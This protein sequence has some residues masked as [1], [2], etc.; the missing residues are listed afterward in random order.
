M[1]NKAH[2]G[3][4][5]NMEQNKFESHTKL[6]NEFLYVLENVKDKNFF[7]VLLQ[8]GIMSFRR[9]SIFLHVKLNR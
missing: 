8:L 5:G 2:A 4:K 6:Q 3:M 7:G 1:T 9:A